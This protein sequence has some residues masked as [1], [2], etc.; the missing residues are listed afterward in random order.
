MLKKMAEDVKDDRKMLY[1]IQCFVY[2]K[3]WC[4][5]MGYLGKENN[6]NNY[7]ELYCVYIAASQYTFALHR[8]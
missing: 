4:E 8:I 1:L 5:F 7:S 2:Y 3:C 6:S